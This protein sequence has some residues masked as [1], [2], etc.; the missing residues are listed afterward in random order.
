MSFEIDHIFIL[1]SEGAPEAQLLIDFGLTEGPNRVHK[2][3]G[4]SNRCFFFNNVMIELLW[5]SNE[6][7][8][9][10]DSTAPTTLWPRW[11]KRNNGASAFGLC[12]RP[13]NG[14]SKQ[15][16]FKS[17][18]YQPKLLFPKGMYVEIA[19]SV[20]TLTEPFIFYSKFGQRHDSYIND[21]VRQHKADFNELTAINMSQ[22]QLGDSDAVS[23]LLDNKIVI[24]HTNQLNII[25]LEFDGG[26]KG[27]EKDFSP[28]LPLKFKY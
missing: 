2:G 11:Q 22:S 21:T 19:N 9:Q 6:R 13:S 16:P 7:E 25:E 23:A 15:S 14:V 18:K 24:Q 1:V 12:L 5:V 8:A 17:W 26:L 20:T 27:K 10:N 28:R 3:Q 4:T